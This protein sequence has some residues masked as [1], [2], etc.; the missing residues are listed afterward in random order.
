MNNKNFFILEKSHILGVAILLVWIT[1]AYFLSQQIIKNQEQYGEL[2]NLSGKQR[3]LSQKTALSTYQ[4]I[5]KPSNETKLQLKSLL[6]QMQA[7]NNFIIKNLPSKKLKEFYINNN[8]L[9]VHVNFYFEQLNLFLES[10]TF[11]QADKI[12]VLSENILP[13]LNEAVTLFVD[14]HL[15]L[16]EQAKNRTLFIYIGTI[17]TLLFIAI[18]IMRPMAKKIG[19]YTEHLEDEI[20]KRIHELVVFSAIFENSNEGMALT[21]SQE[22]ILKINKA[23]TNITGYNQEEVIGKT[24]RIL[25]SGEQDIAF[26]KNMWAEIKAKG[27][28]SGKITNKNAQGKYYD[29]LLTILQLYNQD[30]D[31]TNYVSVFSD[32]SKLHE[33]LEKFQ[34]LIDLQSNIIFVTNGMQVLFA[35]KSF[36]EFFGFDNLESFSRKHSC[37]AD[38]FINDDNFIHLKKVPNDKVWINFLSQIPEQNRIVSMLDKENKQKAFKIMVDKYEENTSIVVLTDISETVEETQVLRTKAEKDKLTGCYNR[39]YLYSSFNIFTKKTFEDGKQTGVL[40]FDIDNFKSI[41]DT[42]GHNRGDEVLKTFSALLRNNIRADDI[43]IRWGG[44]EFILVL[45]VA[46][47]EKAASIAEKFRKLIESEYFTEIKHITCSIG[48]TLH[49]LNEPLEI[50]VEHADK[51]LYKAKQSGRNRVEVFEI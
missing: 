24:P 9:E 33:A 34:K 20:K 42:Y 28:W 49:R 7:D 36:F 21:D 12:S 35:N 13:K 14:E 48:V 29:E 46:S 17:I 39:E 30:T 10:P 6:L 43:I 51:A 45:S 1:F 15:A 50:T 11:E 16:V 37:I 40:I 25:Q 38:F 27:I 8:G 31:T 5:T 26:Y 32:L 22:K 23:F 3:M 47:I 2:I 44:E 41:N 18:F 19:N 4:F